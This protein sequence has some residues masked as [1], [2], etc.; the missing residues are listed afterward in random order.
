VPIL[1]RLLSGVVDAAATGRRTG[2]GE[3]AGFAL[4]VSR[5]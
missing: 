4:L 1:G 3:V 5:K 2:E